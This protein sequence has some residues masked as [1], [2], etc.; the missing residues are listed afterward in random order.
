VQ[1]AYRQTQF[2]L[3]NDLRLFA[4]GMNLQLAIIAATRP[5][6]RQR[7]E[8]AALTGLWSRVYLYCADACSLLVEGGY[9]SSLPLI[10]AAC[11]CLAAE[12][13][14]HAAEMDQFREW[15][16]GTLRPDEQFKATEFALGRYFAGEALASDPHLRVIYRA[17]GDLGRPNFGATL[18][19]VGPESNNLKIALTFADRTF[20]A[21]WAELLL[22]W[23]LRLCERQLSLAATATDI[24]EVSDELRA[25]RERFAQQVEKVLANGLRCRIE[26]VEAGGYKRYLVHNFRRTTSAAP[27]KVLL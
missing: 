9:V 16:A 3:G 7:H 19:Q 22:G 20:H 18:L 26:E 21:A 13:Q 14:L 2:L 4:D 23:L 17:A 10:R 25:Q 1:D 11:E 24:F 8:M 5:T 27:K 15:L 12:I 6:A